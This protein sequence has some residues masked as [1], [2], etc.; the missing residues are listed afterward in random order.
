ML[1]TG[2]CTLTQLCQSDSLPLSLTDQ[3]P[4]EL[5]E[6]THDAQE[7]MRH[8]GVLTSEGKILFLKADVNATLCESEHHLSQIG[9]VALTFLPT[10]RCGRGWA[11]S[12]HL[13]CVEPDFE[14]M[15]QCPGANDVFLFVNVRKFRAG[16]EQVFEGSYGFAGDSV[17]K[18]WQRRPLGTRPDIIYTRT[19]CAP[20]PARRRTPAGRESDSPRGTAGA[21]NPF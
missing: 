10:I 18:G 9:T 12:Q 2:V 6:G 21:C 20:A 1:A 7:Q 14:L 5:S 4:L 16:T 8:R 11:S 3:I 13:V 15:Q 19:T 17:S